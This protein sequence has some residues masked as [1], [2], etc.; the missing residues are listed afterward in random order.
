MLQAE[1]A[2]GT[3]WPRLRAA[4]LEL[5]TVAGQLQGA[6]AERARSGAGP[7]STDL[8]ALLERLKSELRQVGFD[9]RLAS[10]AALAIGLQT[11]L[12]DALAIL[13]RLDVA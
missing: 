8:E 7:D 4:Y 13:D 11:A 10:E 12:G 5:A 6:V 1:L 9:I 2:T 3:P